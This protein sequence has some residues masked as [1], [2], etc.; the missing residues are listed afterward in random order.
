MDTDEKTEEKNR[1]IQGVTYQGTKAPVFD[2]GSTGK[3][4]MEQ[5]RDRTASTRRT[6]GRT[7][8]VLELPATTS[9]TCAIGA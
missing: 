3:V 8:D 9:Q 5:H 1:R 6:R 2:P 7:A 4:A